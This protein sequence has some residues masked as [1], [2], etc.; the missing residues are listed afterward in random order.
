M[1]QLYSSKN[2]TFLRVVE[3]SEKELN[4][5]ICEK[6]KHLFPQYLF[7]KGEFLLNGNV[8]AAGNGGRIDI[9]AYNP[10]THRFVIFELKKDYDRNITDQAADY[11]DFVQDNFAEF[12]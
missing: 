1:P 3:K 11:R 2:G 6:W 9:L 8:R 4:K 7:I 12:A 5:F 10:V